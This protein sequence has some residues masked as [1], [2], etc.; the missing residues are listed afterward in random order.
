[1]GIYQIYTISNTD[2]LQITLPRKKL[3]GGQED[4]TIPLT[5]QGQ[6]RGP[7]E[8]T[9]ISIVDGDVGDAHMIPGQDFNEAFEEYGEVISPVRPKKFYNSEFFNG[10]LM[11]VVKRNDKQLPDRIIVNELSLLISTEERYRIV[12]I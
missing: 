8:G 9:L 3:L 12:H 5:P 1:M 6:H 4:I 10:N 11:I 7:R 2:N